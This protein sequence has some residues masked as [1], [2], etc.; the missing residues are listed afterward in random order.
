M[1]DVLSENSTL[2]H[3]ER[4][5]SL[6]GEIVVKWTPNRPMDAV[7]ISI[8][9]EDGMGRS[10]SWYSVSPINVTG[11]KIDNLPE[12]NDN[13]EAEQTSTNSVL[14]IV[15]GLSAIFVLISSFFIL[16]TRRKEEV[17]LSPWEVGGVLDTSQIELEE[18][19]E[20]DPQDVVELLQG[21]K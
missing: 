6:D 18:Q 20:L 15:V 12:I 19:V 9:C 14:P 7:N 16:Y 13:E 4:N 5:P 8:I 3:L 10:D 11:I 21:E 2:L 1:I 17:D